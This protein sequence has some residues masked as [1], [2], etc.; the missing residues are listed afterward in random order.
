[1]TNEAREP[2]LGGSLKKARETAKL[3]GGQLA[4]RLGWANTTGKSKVSKIEGGRQIPTA[5]EITAWAEATATSDRVRDQWIAMAGQ[6]ADERPN[7]RQRAKAGQQA[8]QQEYT[9]LAEHTVRFTFFETVFV[10]RYLQVPDYSRAV[11]QEHHEKHGSID[12]VTVAAQEK[13]RSVRY[14]YDPAKTFTFLL[15]EPILRRRRFPASI[16]RPQLDRLMSVIG[17]DNVTLA[18]YPSL[19]RPVGS[20]TESSFEI[21]DDI[22]YI[23]TA[24]SDD[25]KLLAADVERLETLFARYW[26]DAVTGDEA[27]ALILDAINQ[28]PA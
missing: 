15:D 23:E 7:Y 18:I 21:F 28:L 25:R 22:A 8:V 9:D 16:M 6:A 3:T 10:P 5:D 20:L 1:M 4:E 12:D 26:Q 24:L 27:R 14:L 13:Q 17:L 11:L 2:L 19:S